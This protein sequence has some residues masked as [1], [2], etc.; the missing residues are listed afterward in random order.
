MRRLFRLSAVF[1]LLALLLSL[2]GCAVEKE[3]LLSVIAPTEPPQ[4]EAAE[5]EA[6]DDGETD[7][8]PEQLKADRI[9]GAFSPFFPG[10][11]GDRLVVE[12][13]QLSLMGRRGEESPSKVSSVTNE[14]GSVTVSIELQG[15]LRFADG[16][17]ISADDLLFTYYVL[18]DPSYDG[19]ST[20][21]SLPI[22]GLDEYYTG[23]TAELYEKYGKLYDEIYNDAK[24]DEDLQK[25]LKEAQDADP[26]NWW[27]EQQAQKAVD[28]YES[29]KADEIKAAI[30]RCWREDA[31]D[32]VNFCMKKF[33]GV[34]ETHTPYTREEVEADPAKQI[35]FAMYE[36]GIGTVN[37]DGTLVGAKTG[38]VWDM[39]TTF[40]TTED[41]YNEMY[42]AYDGIAEDYWA[43]EGVG[44]P[45]MM[46]KARNSCI[47]EWA[48]G[49]EE[50]TG[51][52][53]HVSGID[54][55][56]DRLVTV[57]LAYN[58]AGFVDT[59]T[60]VYLVPMHWYG[61]PALFDLANGRF[62]FPF[63]NIDSVSLKASEP[64]GAG[65][66]TLTDWSSKLAS[67]SV[68]GKYWADLPENPRLEITTE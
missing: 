10:S 16:E 64:M 23:V 27:D 38:N 46:D 33:A 17:S 56:G 39:K 40:P 47:A 12:S 66:Y 24:Y 22:V 34:V 50:F 43:L 15:G 9:T 51:A 30:D 28:E 61:D 44:R 4:A 7:I 67:L 31:Q 52:V 8:P 63:G 42:T 68:N 21:K 1:L 36:W 26:H 25:A 6:S 65:M 29:E 13:T 49:D 58:E 5:I 2:A 53:N 11:D 32:I 41:F 60:D 14:D 57:T 59:L 37:G 18:L 19:E 48:A 62:G 55:V 54:R 45:S 20:L 35:M 3:T